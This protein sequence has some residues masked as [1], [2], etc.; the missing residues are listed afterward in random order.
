MLSKVSYALAKSL[1]VSKLDV[2]RGR[3]GRAI[4]MQRFPDLGHHFVSE[5]SVGSWSR[6]QA[7]AP[8]LESRV[9]L[10]RGKENY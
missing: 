7:C 10:H 3:K 6:Y 1:A 2:A 4:T 8:R 9:M 5:R